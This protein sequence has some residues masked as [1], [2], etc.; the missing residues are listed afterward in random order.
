VPGSIYAGETVVFENT[1]KVF[2]YMDP[3]TPKAFPPDPTERCPKGLEIL[4]LKHDVQL[5]SSG[6]LDS[7]RMGPDLPIHP[8]WEDVDWQVRSHSM[9]VKLPRGFELDVM[10]K[11]ED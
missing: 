7:H 3:G 5:E 1:L 6:E 4:F 10:F 11:E 9:R 2:Q 8:T